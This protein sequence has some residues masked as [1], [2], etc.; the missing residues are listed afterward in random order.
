MASFPPHS[1]RPEDAR[2]SRRP[3][4]RAGGRP[5]KPA[6]HFH[7]LHPAEVSF[8]GEVIRGLGGRPRAISPKFFYDTKGARLFEAI[9][10]TPEYYPTR[11]EIG[12]IARHGEEIASIVGQGSLLIEF[13]SGN[14]RKV[15]L[16][17]ERLRPAAY[18][19]LD[20]CRDQ[21]WAAAWAVGGS[22]PWLDVHAV[23]TDYSQPEW[24]VP[25]L[26]SAFPRKLAF[27]PGS[28]IGNFEPYEAASFLRRLNRLLAPDG[29]ALIGVDLKKDPAILT[30]AYNDRQGITAAFNLNVL[31]RINRELGT[32]FDPGAM[33]HLAFY[34]EGAGRI[35]MHLMSIRAQTVTIG[36]HRF[37]IAPGE[38]IH[39]ENSY[40]YTVEE[41]AQMALRAGFR[42]HRAWTDPEGLFS[43]H[44]LSRPAG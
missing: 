42:S 38:S 36:P 39:T 8:R 6:I 13:G 7:D 10:E 12:L 32:D 24:H 14:S 11:T 25:A 44:Y 34:N 35:E 3:S 1:P 22:H 40:K 26:T 19:P 33:R 4:P 29:A 9:C 28:S 15:R 43:I 2:R 23:C 18:M 21:L 27:F 20:I 37:T 31:E 30:R 16:L 17:L 5:G 41:F